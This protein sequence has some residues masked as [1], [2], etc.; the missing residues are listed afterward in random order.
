[1]KKTTGCL[2][3]LL[4]LCLLLPGLGAGQL[5][6]AD[7]MLQGQS[8]QSLSVHQNQIYVLTRLSHGAEEG[9]QQG[10]EVLRLLPGDTPS[11]FAQLGPGEAV[12]DLLSDGQQLY[13]FNRESGR[14]GIISPQGIAWQEQAMDVAPHH[15]EPHMPA[16][17]GPFL[18]A[19]KLY[20]P[21]DNIA[22]AED[23]APLA[24][25]ESDLKD[26]QTRLIK[27]P[28]AL[29]VKPYK[30]GQ[31]LLLGVKQQGDGRSYYQLSSFDLNSGKQQVLPQ[32]MP[33]A[34]PHTGGIGALAYDKEQDR[35][36]YAD[37]RQAKAATGRQPFERVA[38][39][40]FDYLSP[41]YGQGHVLGGGYLVL[42]GDLSFRRADQAIAV[43]ELT[44]RGQVPPQVLAAFRAQHPKALPNLLEDRAKA[45]QVFL[46]IQGGEKGIDVYILRV[47]PAFR[48][49]L[50]KGYALDLSKD[51]A[52]LADAAALHPRLLQAFTDQGGTLRALPF[53]LHNSANTLDQTAWQELLPESPI[54]S[55]WEEVMQARLAFAKAA[56]QG[57]IFF[58]GGDSPQVIQ[59]LVKAFILQYEE[60]G[61]ALDF[62]HP[63][64]K[65]ALADYLQAKTLR[66][67]VEVE[68]WFSEVGPENHLLG[69]NAYGG[70]LVAPNKEGKLPYLP[71][72]VFEQGQ[73]PKEA[74][75]LDALII[76]P[77]SQNQ[78]L[79][80]AFVKAL[81][82]KDSNPRVYYATHPQDLEPYPYPQE[83]F[84][85]RIQLLSQQKE[86]FERAIKEAQES[87]D[88]KVDLGFLQQRLFEI[89][90][91]LE[92]QESQRYQ[93]T[94]E[95]IRAQGERGQYLALSERSLM[96]ADLPQ[97]QLNDLIA[98]LFEG[99]LALDAFIQ[100][101]NQI[102]QRV[103]QEVQ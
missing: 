73:Q 18:L 50:Q 77:L 94:G 11:T 41:S 4:A 54:P 32:D 81:I 63:L 43:E 46:D 49:L 69:L 47:D 36:F 76:N 37:S 98:Q 67:D 34:F 85:Q 102:S 62:D 9:Q 15:Q 92:N 82:Q 20:M 45:Q 48:S 103:F 31:L 97:E 10:Q 38:L 51:P 87:N 66:L 40:G 30:D 57:Q 1:M 75:Y 39:L 89:N 29:M 24:L 60:E 19:G 91:A 13:G 27:I 86:D 74:V 93:F 23:F 12:F 53:D 7:K 59:H 44:I 2:C 26:G 70:Q 72:F 16:A 17:Q 28:P 35:I 55:T 84:L 3:L 21:L 65:Q 8:P 58:M 88:A 101:A 5:Q 42:A 71:P 68:D 56:P 95:Q 78:D 64:L 6:D 61:R 80:L 14:L 99:Q 90:H 83:E 100:Q 52:L 33:E 22:S 79:A 96:L 25:A